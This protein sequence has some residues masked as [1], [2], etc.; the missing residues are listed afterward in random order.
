M[1]LKTKARRL[2]YSSQGALERETPSDISSASSEV[3][4]LREYRTMTGSLEFRFEKGEFVESYI[5][6]GGSFVS[7]CVVDPSSK[8]QNGNKG[9][10]LSLNKPCGKNFLRLIWGPFVPPK[11]SSDVAH[12]RNVRSNLSNLVWD[13][14]QVQTVIASEN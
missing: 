13:I 11:M 2:S 10:L 3:Q 6:M 5:R 8:C 1:M 4:S 9:K 14:L 7:H 12:A